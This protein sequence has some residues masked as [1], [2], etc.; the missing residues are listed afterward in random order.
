MTEPPVPPPLPGDPVPPPPGIHGPMSSA[1][2]FQ[3]PSSLGTLT[4]V[5]L[6]VNVAMAFVLL[7]STVAEVRLIERA[8]TS[9]N[10]SFEEAER[11]DN[12]QRALAGASTLAFV[13]AGIVW[14][15]W[16]HR[17]HSN[18][19][20]LGVRDLRFTHGWAVGGFIV[21]VLNLVRAP[22]VMSELLRASDPSGGATEWKTKPTPQVVVAW[23]ATYLAGFIV[24]QVS[25][26]AFRNGTIDQLLLSDR[27]VLGTQVLIAISGVLAVTMVRRVVTAQRARAAALQPPA[28]ELGPA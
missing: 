11:N 27:I 23:W 7:I 2:T 6:L 24:R 14:L 26:L 28:P 20:A 5:L 18:L 15:V 3:D 17:A 9:G 10:I 1:A 19:D 25:V 21:P 4:I 12:R 22:Q 13:A 8:Q 16:L